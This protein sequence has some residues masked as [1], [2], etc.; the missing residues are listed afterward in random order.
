MGAATAAL[1]ILSASGQSRA[2]EVITSFD[3]PSVGIGMICNTPDQAQEYLS[4]RADGAMAQDAMQKDNDKANDPH[5][6]G[7]AA[8][9]FVRDQM[10]KAHTVE[11]KLLE[12]VQ[13]NVVAGFDGSAWKSI[14]A[15][16]QYAVMEGRGDSI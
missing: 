6:C 4:L 16:V 14:P 9:A 1:M 11:N 10:L 5:A 12:V 2:G 7:V 13:I 8:I 3:Q 15:M